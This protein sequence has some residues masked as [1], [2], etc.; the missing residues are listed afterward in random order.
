MTENFSIRDNIWDPLFPHHSSYYNILID[1][2][3]SLNLC[4]SKSTNQVLTKYID[5]QNGL[6]LVIDLDLMFLWLT[7]AEFDN[8]TIHSKQRLSLDYALFTVN[9][10]IFEEHVQTKKQIIV[11]NS[12]KER[13]FIA[14]LTKSI[15]RLNTE[16]ITSKEDLE[17]VVQEF[18]HNIDEIWFKHSKI[19]NVTKHSK[20]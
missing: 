10:T 14:E 18:V 6:N 13:N 17:Q 8:H 12:K 15:K 20:S 7:S 2:A 3:E 9:I 16:Y 19:V 4:I 5:N 11:K 1:T